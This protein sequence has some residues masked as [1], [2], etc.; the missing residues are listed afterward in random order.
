MKVGNIVFRPIETGGFKLDGGAMFGVVP[1]VLWSKTNPS[2]QNNRIDMSMRALFIGIDGHNI[3]IDSG[4][5]DKLG[6]KMLRNYLIQ[7]ERLTSVLKRENI[8][9]ESIT[10]AV[11]SHL[12]FDHAGGY[13]YKIGEDRYALSCPQAVHF[14]QKRQWDAACN[15]NEKDRA[16]FFKENFLPIRE[17]GK[18]QL[19]NGKKEILPGVTV[20]PTEG[21]TPGHQVTLVEKGDV[22]L[23]YC[24]DL[25]PLASH[26]NLPYIM[27]YDHF[28]LNTLREKKKLLER[29]VTEKW[30]LFFEHD[31]EIAACRIGKNNKGRY[32]IDE[33]ID[34]G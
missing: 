7:S 26:I 11:V 6:E 31:P 29:A 10:E 22:K 16:S 30:I 1:K 14:I 18:L 4:A 34:M 28:P 5:G 12:H 3:L 2:D 17:Q 9:P 19:L 8:D 25:I 13:T 20:I 23:L 15:P 32:E 27:A 33:V 21:H 24:A